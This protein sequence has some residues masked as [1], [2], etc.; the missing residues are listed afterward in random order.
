MSLRLL[1]E[2]NQKNGETLRFLR[3]TKLYVRKVGKDMKCQNRNCGK[4]FSDE[5]SFCP[6]CA[7]PAAKIICANP[8]CGFVLDVEM[9]PDFKFCPECGLEFSRNASPVSGKSTPVGN[10]KAW[11]NNEWVLADLEKL[12]K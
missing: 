2:N 11:E 8:D 10:P 7:T 9:P 6:H 3:K 12:L 5:F 4:D 1:W